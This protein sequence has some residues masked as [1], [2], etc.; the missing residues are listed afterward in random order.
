MTAAIVLIG[1]PG[2]GK[3]S[4]GR[5]LAKVSSLPFVDTDVL[6]EKDQGKSISEIF[7][8]DGEGYFRAV[9]ERICLE[10]LH[11]SSGIIS[12]G[13]GA[14]LSAN[15]QNALKSSTM[16]IVFLDVSL[17]VAAPRIGFNRDRPLLLNHFRQQWQILMDKRR[18]IYEEVATLKIEVGQLSVAAICDEILQKIGTPWLR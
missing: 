12:L 1:P 13:G 18:P 8:D 6:I 15:V 11:E 3:T 16:Q 4:V 17:S 10:I 2:A 7:V 9:E 14:P 5:A